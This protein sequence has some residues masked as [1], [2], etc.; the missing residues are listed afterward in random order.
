MEVF[1]GGNDAVDEAEQARHI[2]G[3]LRAPQL[4]H[5][6]AEP[7]GEALDALRGEKRAC[8]LVTGLH[9]RGGEALTL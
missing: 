8:G 5:H 1:A 4:L 9:Y 6:Q 3:R 7:V 2:L